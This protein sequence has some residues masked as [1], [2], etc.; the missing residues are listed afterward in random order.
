MKLIK[1]MT[2]GPRK[3]GRAVKRARVMKSAEIDHFE[4]EI[5]KCE[6]DTRADTICA[7]INFRMLSST[8]Q[9]CDVKGFHDDFDT[10]KDVPIARVATAYKDSDGRTWI[11][12]IN[13]ALYFGQNMDHS[14][15]NPNQI[16]HF[17]IPVSDNA[18]DGANEFGIDHEDIF[19][20]F[21][22]KGATVFFETYVPSDDD[23]EHNP[24]IVLTDGDTEWDPSNIEMSRNRPY[25]D[26]Y[27]VAVKA[28]RR[29]CEQRTRAPIE[30]ESDLVLGSISGSFVGATMYERLV[31]SVRVTYPTS[32]RKPSKANG[33]TP[34]KASKAL[35]NSRHSKVTPE[36]LARTLNIGL[37]KAKQML[38]VT[39]QKGIRTATH[40]IHRRYRV[41]HLDLHSSRLR[42]KW[43]VDWMASRTKS[44]QS[45]KGAFIYTNGAFTEAYPSET[46]QQIP[47]NA[48]LND[49]CH[50]VGIPEKLA[51]DR[52]PEFCGRN[53]E[54]LKNA[55]GKGIDLTYAEPERKNQIYKVDL[56]IRELRKRVHNKMRSKNVPKRLWDFCLKHSAK[57]MQFL[58]RATLNG[59]TGYEYVTGKTPDISEFIDFDFYD[60]V[61]YSPGAHMSIS[62]DNREI[63]RWLGVSHK[64]GSD[65]CYWIM[66]ASGIPIAETTVQHVT[67]DDM[68]DPA[69]ANHIE[70]FNETLTTRLDDTNFKVNDIDHGFED[71]LDDIPQWDMAYG[72]N[73]PPDSEY[74]EETVPLAEAEDDI[75]PDV[76]DKY[77]GARVLLTNGENGGGNIATVKSRVTDL[78]GRATGNAHNNPLLDDREYEIELEDGTTDRIFAN[79]I[80]ENIYSQLDDEGREILKFRDIVDHR[81][82][83]SALTKENGFIAQGRG[84]PKPKKT[85]RGW[86]VLVEW[87]DETT[88]WMNLVDVKDASPI[89]LAEYAVANK[90]HD[91]P[92][93]AWWV[94]YCL[95]KRSRIIAKV[96]TKYWKTT[97]KYGVRLPKNAEQALRLDQESGTKLWE[98]AIN[99][100]MKKAKVAYNEVDDCTPDDVRHGKV[101][102]LTGF[103]E[104]SCHL[105]FDVKMD[106]TRKA[107]FVANG[108]TTDAPVALCYS[109]VV[110][111]DSVRIAF[112]VAS[113]NDLDV[114]ACDIGNAY[115]NAPCQEKIWFEAGVECGRE[116]KGRVMKLCRALYGLKSSGASWRRMFKD[117]I[118]LKMNFT[119]STTDPDMYYRKNVHNDGTEYYELLLVYVDDV[120]AISHDPKSIMEM[121]GKGFDL[122][123]DEYGPPTTYLGG[124]VE[125]FILPDGT[126]A[127][128]IMSNSY[129]KGAVDTVKAL[130]A[131]DGRE[132]KSGKRPHKGP[133]PSGYKPELDVTDEC[134]AEHVSRFQQ[135]IGILRWAIELGRI[136][137][138]I[139]VA[140]LSQYQASPRDGHL[141]ALYL[142]FHY[143]SKNPK[144]RLVMDP[145]YPNVD[146]N[147]FN[148]SADWMQ[149][150]GDLVE[151]DPP[152]MPVPLGRP[153]DT[154]CFEDADHASNVVTQ[155]SHT[156]IM[157]F[158]QNALI[159]TYSKRQNTV[160]SSTFGSELVALRI[161]RD[162]IV[163][164]RLKL[165]SIGVPLLGATNVYCD[166]QGVVK[167]TSIPESTLNKKHNSINY[168]VVR[169]AV[170]ANI[171]RVGKEDTA[172]NLADPLTKLMP[173]TKKQETMG[174]V[175]WDY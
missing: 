51:S 141:E 121:I 99:K 10:I 44:I 108:S 144:K 107:R 16:R 87:A 104:I 94:P 54:F 160:E 166:N 58:P 151:E 152:R 80:A 125:K 6:L 81:K 175:Q 128:S 15:I 14:L 7:G 71:D 169:E 149:F 78:N 33:S 93:F 171:M 95:R 158:V 106:F 9:T 89:E 163:E 173:F 170:A 147:T 97:H 21:V 168:H 130:L 124:D 70:T 157:L 145:N 77:L 126:S 28:A 164:L 113:L 118:E 123:N 140:L 56:E 161:A 62:D 37:D 133:L 30:Y 102:E 129:V 61:W 68:I 143:L 60:L 117:Y 27:D 5:A 172:Y 156:G 35:S 57:V 59:Q 139:E 3:M 38:R 92:A 41:D 17:G 112:L 46:N 20:P 167:N 72:D 162:L 109:S 43:Y 66:G 55:K 52:A 114:F 29:I 138:Q 73:T 100:E 131:E 24:H 153:V 91:E 4:H 101:P 13:E 111:R 63:G 150:Y 22:T 146:E 23:L 40:P 86:K 79:K 98:T 8:G 116:M 137:V 18:Y 174:Q 103:Q 49:F 96:K 132:L 142:I 127:W 88:T 115:L 154:T 47:A 76:L 136:D 120:L 45:N 31:S 155:R 84:T 165:K 19:I 53:S 50:D 148:G 85:T 39:T 65:M 64:I 134:D 122:K 34:R 36:H 90:I 26:N 159:K 2:S 1:K 119:P 25:G 75:D 12:I 83:G 42:G 11:L 110:S 69:I 135:L 82:D 48:S 67:R 32:K 105:I 74:D